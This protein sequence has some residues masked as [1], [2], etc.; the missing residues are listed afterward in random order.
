MTQSP[1]TLHTQLSIQSI[2]IHPH[3][4]HLLQ[5]RYAYKLP[6]WI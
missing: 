4:F 6:F 3:P 2:S 5:C 1:T